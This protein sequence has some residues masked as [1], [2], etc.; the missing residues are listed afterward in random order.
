MI[1]FKPAQAPT[2]GEV[3]VR[4][5]GLGAEPLSIGRL[6]PDAGHAGAELDIGGLVEV[7]V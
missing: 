6:G 3:P 7:W 2:T 5:Q 1:E 4:R